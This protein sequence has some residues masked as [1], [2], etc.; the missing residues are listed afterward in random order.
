M[1]TP[2]YYNK[3]K[4]VGLFVEMS[5]FRGTNY[6]HISLKRF[7]PDDEFWFNTKNLA[8]TEEYV[9]YVIEGLQKISQ[10]LA[11]VNLP[12]NI[13]MEFDFKGKR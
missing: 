4:D 12:D 7:D 6:I 10:Q 13:Q 8:L 3:E 5:E 11:K 2:L 1:K 9:D